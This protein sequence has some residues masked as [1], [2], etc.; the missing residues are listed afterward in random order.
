MEAAGGVG[1]AHLGGV[2]TP[3]SHQLPPLPGSSASLLSDVWEGVFCTVCFLPAGV[4]NRI[5]GYHQEIL[6]AV[7]CFSFYCSF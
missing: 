6:R 3:V 1:T 2:E 4:E 7:S 5:L